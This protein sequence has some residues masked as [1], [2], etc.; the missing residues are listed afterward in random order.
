MGA[1]ELFEAGGNGV[2]PESF[3]TFDGQAR[4][5]RGHLED[6]HAPRAHGAV[7]GGRL[8]V[9][10]GGIGADDA[11]LPVGEGAER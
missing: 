2:E 8:A 1:V 10:A 6:F 3:G 11:A 5:A 4:A 7:E 9:V